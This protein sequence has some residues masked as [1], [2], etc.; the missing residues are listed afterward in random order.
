M[1]AALQIRAILFGRVTPLLQMQ[2]GKSR[3]LTKE[4]LGSS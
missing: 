3:V 2:P 4:T 1:Q